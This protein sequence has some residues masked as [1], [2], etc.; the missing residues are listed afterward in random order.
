MLVN[1]ANYMC[2]VHVNYNAKEPK[3]VTTKTPKVALGN[4]SGREEIT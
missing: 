1:I 4:H 3:L 2:T